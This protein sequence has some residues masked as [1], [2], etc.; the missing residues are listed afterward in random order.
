MNHSD[1]TFEDAELTGSEFRSFRDLI[2]QRTS[3]TLADNKKHLLEARLRKRIRHLNLP[4]YA[5]Y[6]KF[7]E[8]SDPR[9]EELQQMIN[10]VTTNKTNFFREDHHFA[11][12]ADV[13]F[14]KLIQQASRG[15]RPERLRI[16]SAACST[17]EEPYSLAMTVLET[18][19]ALPGWDIRILASDI[20]TDVIAAAQS[21]IYHA[22]KADDVPQDLLQKYFLKGSGQSTGKIMLRPEVTE[23]VTFRQI[24]FTDPEWSIRTVFDVI[25]CRNVMIYFDDVTQ[26]RLT[27]RF[28]DFL[29][30]QG[31]LFIGHSESLSRIPQTYTR[32]D[33]TV[34]QLTET[35]R[36]QKAPQRPSAPSPLPARLPAAPF[37][38]QSGDGAGNSDLNRG[39]SGSN[40]LFPAPAAVQ[41]T[42]RNVRRQSII[43]GE[44]AA[45]QEPTEISTT[46]GSC[47]ATC[48]YDEQSGIGGMNHFA[49]PSGNSNSRNSASFGIHAMELL[50]N[51]IMTLGG[52]RRHLKAK[53]FG[54]ANVCDLG[55]GQSV[56]LKNAAFVKGFLQTE[57]IPIEAEYL[58]GTCGIQVQFNTATGKARVRML[59]QQA[60]A[61]AD[62]AINTIPEP[63]P[64]STE[65]DITLF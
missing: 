46:L 65:S 36:R 62:Q 35:A 64:A 41:S 4:T 3:I 7:L 27:T 26:D 9:G 34:Y 21:A 63:T 18:F 15:E 54:G 33:K 47:I 39:A 51:R 5:A 1:T 37:L 44:V 24:N 61:V 8:R 10:R 55:T 14:P 53:V 28:V 40:A 57:G 31:Y 11:Y 19:S 42:S 38:P 29:D 13:V 25:F 23:L 50:I 59:D 49:L 30:P 60:A 17:G 12:L 32:V 2:Y 6:F 22:D 43:V 56:G 48:L 52:D 16:W 45:S 20:D 58:G